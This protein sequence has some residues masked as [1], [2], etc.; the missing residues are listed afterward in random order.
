MVMG[1]PGR[2]AI[3]G[4]SITG[5]PIRMP[6][7]FAARPFDHT[8]NLNLDNPKPKK[9]MGGRKRRRKKKIKETTWKRSKCIASLI[10]TMLTGTYISDTLVKYGS[11]NSPRQTLYSLAHDPIMVNLTGSAFPIKRATTTR[12][13]TKIRKDIKN[14]VTSILKFLRSTLKIIQDIINVRNENI[15]TIIKE[16]IRG[17]THLLGDR[18][19]AENTRT[20][21]SPTKC[22]DCDLCNQC[23]PKPMCPYCCIELIGLIEYIKATMKLIINIPYEILKSAAWIHIK[24]LLI[25]ALSNALIILIHQETTPYT[26]LLI[27]T[28]TTTKR[29]IQ[30]PDEISGKGEKAYIA[31]KKG[32]RRRKRKKPRKRN[33]NLK[34]H[35][36]HQA[37]LYEEELPKKGDAK[38]GPPTRNKGCKPIPK[39][40]NLETKIG[41]YDGNADS[42]PESDEE[43]QGP[44]KNILAS[45]CG[46]HRTKTEVHPNGISFWSDPDRPPEEIIA[47]EGAPQMGLPPNNVT[48]NQKNTTHHCWL[49]ESDE[50]VEE[51]IQIPD[52]E[53]ERTQIV[54]MNVRSY[55]SGRKRTE[56]RDGISTQ[57]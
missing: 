53:V 16:V 48:N 43:D 29:Y 13:R 54:T 46:W 18:I 40:G 2:T 27:R 52:A 50:V 24:H 33:T 26:G 37:K 20:Y 8:S 15:R 3:G 45:K 55:Y 31:Q 11:P 4:P 14:M 10:L 22:E 34:W 35:Q 41:Q 56:V 25:R 23:G 44:L 17:W 57:M 12:D 47:L 9:Y 6:R 51:D 7:I 42:G 21:W 30:N 38:C 49:N 5:P 1:S 39:A 32:P 28:L 36:R 19:S